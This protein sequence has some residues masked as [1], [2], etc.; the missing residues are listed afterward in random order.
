MANIMIPNGGKQIGLIN[1]PKVT[2]MFNLSNIRS[3]ANVSGLKRLCRMMSL[4][5]KVT[6]SLFSSQLLCCPSI[7]FMSSLKILKTIYYKIYQI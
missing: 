6:I 2:F 4:T 3:K 7:T 1:C 5:E